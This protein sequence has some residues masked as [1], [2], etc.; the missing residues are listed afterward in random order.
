MKY[1]AIFNQTLPPESSGNAIDF[2]WIYIYIYMIYIKRNVVFDDKY[3]T[4]VS[5]NYQ[6][7]YQKSI[8]SLYFSHIIKHVMVNQG[9]LVLGPVVFS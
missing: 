6:E 4:P 8:T 3:Y 1:I 7:T 5:I 9:A 2:I